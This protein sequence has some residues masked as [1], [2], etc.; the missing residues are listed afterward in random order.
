MNVTG[1]FWPSTVAL[2]NA[3]AEVEPKN[4]TLQW[5]KRGHNGWEQMVKFAAAGVRC[6]DACNTLA[7]AQAELHNRVLWGRKNDHTQGRDIVGPFHARWRASEFWV[8]PIPIKDE[9][10]Q[11]VWNGR[12]IRIGAKVQTGPQTRHLPVRSRKNGWTIDYGANPEEPLRSQIRAASVAAVKAL[13]YPGGAVDVILGEDGLVYVLE[14]NTAPSL[15][16]ERT[17]EAYVKAISKWA[18]KQQQV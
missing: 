10:R 8:A 18:G 7:E 17:L 3:L 11:H 14:V 13:D 6:P 15:R 5:G 9:Y 16:D 4:F 1:P 2:R 12:C